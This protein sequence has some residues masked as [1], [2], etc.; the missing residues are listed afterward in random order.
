MELR[1]ACHSIERVECIDE[2]TSSGQ[3]NSVNIFYAG[4]VQICSGAENIQTV[5][6]VDGV[7]AK[8]ERFFESFAERLCG[9]ML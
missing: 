1:G 7:D 9:G 5:A 8:S 6:I 4:A 2:V 3:V